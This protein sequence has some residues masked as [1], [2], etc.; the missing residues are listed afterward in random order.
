MENG[1]QKYPFSA[2]SGAYGFSAICDMN[3]NL[4][5]TISA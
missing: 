5:K 1:G 4:H 2:G 3:K